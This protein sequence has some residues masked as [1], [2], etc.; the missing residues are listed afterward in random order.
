MS[1]VIIILAI[2]LVLVAVVTGVLLKLLVFS[3]DESND[4]SESTGQQCVINPFE[5]DPHPLIFYS[6]TVDWIYPIHG[7]TVLRFEQGT[8][9]DFI[10]P[11]RQIIINN[12]L[13]EKESL[14]GQCVSDTIFLID[15]VNI[16]WGTLICSNYHWKSIEITGNS[17]IGDGKELITG[18]ETDDGRFITALTICF[19]PQLEIAYYTFI[20]QT[21]T[22]NQRVLDTPRPSFIQGFGI[23]TI[24]SATS[25]YVRAQ[26]RATINTL[27]G[28]P[29]NSTKYIQDSGNYFLSR[30][31]MTARSDGFYAAQ[32][33]ATFYMQ[34]IAPQWHTVNGANW[35][36]IEIDLR[37]YAEASASDLQV[38]CG[39]YGVTTLPHEE[40]GDE[41]ELYLFVNSTHKLLPVPEFY[42]KVAY[43][44]LTKAAVALIGMNNPYKES[45]TPIC[46]DISSNLSWFTCNSELVNGYCYACTVPSF[47][48]IVTTLPDFTTEQLLT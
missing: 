48:K 13:T 26:Q 15:G 6:Q 8:S 27:V 4:E 34:N 9:L 2:A 42:W 20:N 12:T 18:F 37:D 10:C 21:S 30:G 40:T 31:H 43:N 19:N 38:Y 25:Y 47:R 7:E 33:N 23:Y 14:T 17:C 44:S 24:G 28:L 35:N 45:F 41:I 3:N 46:E 39:V 11:G 36:Q 5:V 32:Q 1:K 16:E 22:I 29:E